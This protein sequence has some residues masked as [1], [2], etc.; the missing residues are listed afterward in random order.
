[1][2]YTL[3]QVVQRILE[4]MDSDEV[5]SYSDTIESIAVANIVKETYYNIVS[6]LDLPTNH[7]FFQLNAS[8][9]NTKPV[10]MTLPSDV[11]NLDYIKYKKTN[12]SS[13]TFD[14]IDYV[15]L[16][17]FVLRTLNMDESETNISTMTVSL[18]GTS[19]MFKYYNDRQP[20][21]Y[22]TVDNSVLLFDAFDASV[23]NTLQASKTMCYGEKTQTF[24]MNDSFVIPLDGSELQ[25]LIN[26]A[27]SQA[28]IEL[29][30]TQNVHSDT[31]ARKAF[32]TTQRTKDKVPTGKSGLSKAP[33]FGKAS[34]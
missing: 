22:T 11:L 24:T 34:A 14:D 5:N 6:R 16:E 7:S 2:K 23:E 10:L 30:Q 26:E 29:K 1:M 17:E 33:K 31:R 18:G 27:R 20:S 4:S 19:F 13:T 15:P 3:L 8:G 25:V 32:I 21:F 9:D 28:F 12:G